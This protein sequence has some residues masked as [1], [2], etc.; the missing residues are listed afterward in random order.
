MM[1]LSITYFIFFGGILNFRN[2][3]FFTDFCSLRYY[4]DLNFHNLLLICK[5]SELRIETIMNPS[6][7]DKM[8]EIILCTKKVKNCTFYVNRYEMFVRVQNLH[9]KFCTYFV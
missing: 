1:C 2:F 4:S 3:R 5:S 7:I 9:C 8:Y 6:S